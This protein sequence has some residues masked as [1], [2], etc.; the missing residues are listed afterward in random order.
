[1][2]LQCAG[3]MLAMRK[4]RRVRIRTR[5]LLLS[6]RGRLGSVFSVSRS[7]PAFRVFY[8]WDILPRLTALLEPTYNQAQLF[9]GIV[10]SGDR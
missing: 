8:L 5:I 3:I 1:M 7:T 2:E 10:F 9:W 4:N 6:A